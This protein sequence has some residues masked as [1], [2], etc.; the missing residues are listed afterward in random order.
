MHMRKMSLSLGE[1]EPN[2]LYLLRKISIPERSSRVMNK[3][4][5]SSLNAS[6]ILGCVIIGFVLEKNSFDLDLMWLSLLP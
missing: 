6:L 3:W 4:Q 1:K 2:S 5:N